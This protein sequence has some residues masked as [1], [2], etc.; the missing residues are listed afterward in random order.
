MAPLPTSALP[1]TALSLVVTDMSGFTRTTRK[2]GIIH[3]TSL[4]WKTRQTLRA[5]F[6]HYGAL[7]IRTEADNNFAVFHDPVS[8]LSAALQVQQVIDA[9]NASASPAF[10][11]TMGGVGVAHGEV[12]QTEHLYTGT[13][14]FDAFNL[15]EDVS[16]K[17][18]VLVTGVVR[19]QVEGSD[20]MHEVMFEQRADDEFHQGD[21]QFYA[22]TGSPQPP[23]TPETA[24]LNGLT[25][26]PDIAD[27]VGF[28]HGDVV[29]KFIA[30]ML[31]RFVVDEHTLAD[32]DKRI[33][34]AYLQDSA[35]LMYGAAWDDVT[36]REGVAHCEKLEREAKRIVDEVVDGMYGGHVVEDALFVFEH[37]ADAVA[38][39][40]ELKKRFAEHGNV[41]YT[42]FG[43][44]LGKLLF[45][46]GTNV[47]WGDPVNTASKLGQDYC[48]NGEIIV[49]DQAWDKAKENA[50]GNVKSIVDALTA[51]TVEGIKISGVEFTA[52]SV[53]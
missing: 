21:V 45:A 24:R 53:A 6:S 26:G 17:R 47:H 43:V 2:Y 4:I 33:A 18:E 42:G 25:Q 39:A 36:Q 3:M 20:G 15:G 12:K 48:K 11:I 31:S 37:P 23:Y 44:H 9:H 7:S 49:S 50:Q 32:V 30:P 29:D 34:D 38:A 8:A 52:Y 14:F 16:A 51:Q 13:A 46:E 1:S 28:E 5:L 27:S 22:V 10:Q 41:P 35:V 40:V 19:E